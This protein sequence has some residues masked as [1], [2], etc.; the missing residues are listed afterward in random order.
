MAAYTYTNYDQTKAR[1]HL[2]K[3]S[4]KA[5]LVLESRL[6]NRLAAIQHC[7]PSWETLHESLGRDIRAI[8]D[9]QLLRKK[10]KA[11]Q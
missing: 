5:L 8:H 10:S 4:D 2:K 3:M 7:I 1:L 9:E 11:K 6:S